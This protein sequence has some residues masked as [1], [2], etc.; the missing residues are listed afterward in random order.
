MH[1]N[2]FVVLPTALVI[3]LLLGP[4]CQR[5]YLPRVAPAASTDEKSNTITEAKRN[6]RYFILR[7]ASG[8]YQMT[9]I[10]VDQ[11]SQTMTAQLHTLPEAHKHYIRF[12]KA[13][14]YQKSKGED[15]VL[16]EVHIYTKGS[17]ALD[18][19]QAI[20]LPLSAVEKIEVIEFDKGRTTVSYV[21]GGVGIAVGAV[22]VMA[23]IVALTKSSCP[24]VAVYDGNTYNVQGELFGGAIYPSLERADY[25]ALQARP[26]DGTFR[27]R[28]SN[29]LQEKQY[30]NFANLLVIKHDKDTRVA[31]DAD[32][33]I[34]TLGN[35]LVQG[36]AVLNERQD[37][38]ALVSG[39]DGRNCLFDDTTVASAVNNLVLLFPNPAHAASAKMVLQLKNSYWFDYLFGEFSKAF[40]GYYPTWVKKQEKTPAAELNKWSVE[41]HIPLTVSLKTREGWK[42]VRNLK[43]I[44]P[45]TNRELVI[46]L[47]LKEAEGDV[48]EVRLSTGFMFWEL[49]YAGLDVSPEKAVKVYTL[50]PY[51]AVDEK[52]RNVLPALM[53][54]DGQYLDQPQ[55]GT[56]AYLAYR[57]NQPVGPGETVSVVLHTQGY[58]RHVRDYSGPPNLAFLRPFKLPGTFAAFSRS[59]FNAVRSQNVVALHQ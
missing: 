54:N 49:D 22:A 29:E 43:T 42:E 32:G 1:R 25:V 3:L 20:T 15:A 26:I 30:T 11:Q 12:N 44:G 55:P 50:H 2:R 57:F 17:Q 13:Y 7:S 21:L 31:I 19:A 51:E 34:Y 47:D 28:I 53:Y 37:V 27:L 48:V 52:G 24:F 14:R 59:R 8:N 38:T 6:E 5:F 58:Y 18:T 36:K 40:G 16:N 23:V 45:L 9:N 46:P 39:A 4:S 41:Q 56:A 33:R 35:T 10:Q